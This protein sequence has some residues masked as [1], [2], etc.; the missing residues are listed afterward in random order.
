MKKSAIIVLSVCAFLLLS[1]EFVIIKDYLKFLCV[2]N[3]YMGQ[4]TPGETPMVFCPQRIS[5]KNYAEY[6]IHFSKDGREFFFTRETE[7]N[8]PTIF[9]SRHSTY[10]WSMPE[11]MPFMKAYPGME[12]CLFSGDQKFCFVGINFDSPESNCDFYMT[13]RNGDGW[14]SPWRLTDSPLGHIRNSPSFS[15]NNNLYFSGD[16]DNTGQKDIYVSEYAGGNYLLPKN[17]GKAV[18]SEYDEEHVFVAK[19]E[20]YMLFDSRRPGNHGNSDL[21]ISLRRPDGSWT[22]AQNLERPINSDNS[23]WS[24]YVSPDNKYLFFSRTISGETDIYWV[25]AGFINTYIKS[26]K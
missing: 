11:P 12:S 19:D 7:E 16:Y 23:E 8:L 4:K 5:T 17:L 10:K 15:K 24:P 18:N 22:E 1:F 6:G 3:L 26:N 25:S 2:D 9:F 20:S 14:M 13:V 21:Y